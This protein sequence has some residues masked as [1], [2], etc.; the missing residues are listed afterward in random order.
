MALQV[1]REAHQSTHYRQEALYQWLLMV[2][3]IHDYSQL[4]LR[5][6][7]STSGKEHPANE[8]DKRDMGFISELGRSPGGGNDNPLQ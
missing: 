4:P 2:H 6:P 8:G 3:Q 5:F 1:L 7:C